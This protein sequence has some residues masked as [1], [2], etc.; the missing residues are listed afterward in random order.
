[1]NIVYLTSEYPALSHTFILQEI[2]N[3]RKINNAAQVD[4]QN[5]YN[6]NTITIYIASIRRP[7]NIEYMGDAEQ[8]EYQETFY[9][10]E[11]L[12]S[13]GIVQFLGLTL[14]HPIK[15]LQLSFYAMR[16]AFLS[17][18]KSIIK[19][20]AYILEA[21]LLL[22]YCRKKNAQ[23]IHVHFANPAATVAMLAATFDHISFSISAHGPDI[24][25]DCHENLL[26]LKAERA[27]FIRCISHYCASQFMRIMPAEDWKKL[28]VVRCG[29][30]VN[31]F[32]PLQH[33]QYSKDDISTNKVIHFVCIGRLCSA[34]AQLLLIEVFLKV[35]ADLKVRDIEC[36]LTIA[37]TFNNA[38]KS[39]N[40]NIESY[41]FENKVNQKDIMRLNNN[42]AKE[43][44]SYQ[45]IVK[46]TKLNNLHSILH[47]VGPVSQKE[48]KELYQKTDIF[49][50]PSVAE[51]VPIV[52][53][54]AMAM[55]IPCI[56]TQITGICELITHEKNGMLCYAGDKTTLYDCMMRLALDSVLRNTVSKAG[57]KTILEKYTISTNANALAK[58][59]QQY[60]K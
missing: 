56:S 12:L 26:H 46:D 35:Y 15:T 6:K 23:H 40:D 33:V 22:T 41:I 32:S 45:D 58:L 52:L 24:F 47:F 17:G 11:K 20:L 2:A 21:S 27:L 9:I 57:R 3:L 18:P 50:L 30:D 25:Y 28:H 4:S 34:K 10:Q 1:M 29:V 14:R 60:L 38:N 49:V 37:G 54:E 8:K 7:Q 19:A 43:I 36:K 42:L 51:G 31:S 55:E 13:S 53:M 39:I 44:Q 5:K 59:Y 16:W 48:V